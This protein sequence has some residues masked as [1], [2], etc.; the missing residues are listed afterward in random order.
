MGW[1]ISSTL[2]VKL[3]EK[4][5]AVFSLDGRAL[6]LHGVFVS[7]AYSKTLQQSS[8]QGGTK[9]TSSGFPGGRFHSSSRRHSVFSELQVETSLPPT[10]KL[11][12]NLHLQPF[13]HH[14]SPCC[15]PLNRWVVIFFK[16]SWIFHYALVPFSGHRTE[17]TLSANCPI[18]T[19]C[20]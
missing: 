7:F 19:C 18:C 2:S 3:L 5:Y 20:C 15:I 12:Y 4:H 17:A 16:F 13:Y 1:Y 6:K 8:P 10:I 9:G 11:L 14:H